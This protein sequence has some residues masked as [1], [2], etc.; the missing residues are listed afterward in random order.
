MDAHLLQSVVLY[1]LLIPAELE[2]KKINN[3]LSIQSAVCYTAI[4]GAKS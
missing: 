1:W 4:H 3:S 2:T